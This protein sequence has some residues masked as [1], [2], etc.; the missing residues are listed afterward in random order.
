MVPR[1]EIDAFPKDGSIEDLLK[2][3]IEKG[4]S[5]IPVYNESLDDIVGMVHLRDV[6][7]ALMNGDKKN[8][9]ET[10]INSNVT[11]IS[12][13]MHI[14]DLLSFMQKNKM[15]LA[16]V[17]DEYGGVDG[18][19]TIEDLLEEIVGDI[20][21]EYD[22]D[23]EPA[24]IR[25]DAY[26]IVADASA[27]LEEIKEKTGIDL[28]AN[29]EEEESSVDTLGG[30]VCAI[31]ERLPQRGEVIE[32]KDGLQFRVL[33]VDARRIKKVMIVMKHEAKNSHSVAA[34]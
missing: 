32:T 22:V 28:C 29:R 21:D 11:F 20:Q 14:S 30:L 31:A 8:K 12:P 13:S 18:L 7:Q 33:D 3:M 10:L 1:A 23:P 27:E 4:H 24:I 17:V 34:N 5:K 19:V 25:K 16:L 9:V 6:A 15:H 26:T 2:L